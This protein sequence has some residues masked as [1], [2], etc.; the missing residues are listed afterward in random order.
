MGTVTYQS[1]N[2]HCQKRKI[3]ILVAGPTASSSHLIPS[4]RLKASPANII[5]TTHSPSRSP[6]ESST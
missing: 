6:E 4:P 2:L 5:I 1:L 3:V